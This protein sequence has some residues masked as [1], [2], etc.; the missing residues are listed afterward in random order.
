MRREPLNFEHP[1]P[2]LTLDE[3]YPAKWWEAGIF[4]L[5]EST[6]GPYMP[7]LGLIEVEE[8]LSAKLLEDGRCEFVFQLNQEVNDLFRVFFENHRRNLDV[9]FDGKLMTLRCNSEDLQE[10]YN[11][12]ETF[13]LPRARNEYATERRELV[14]Q[15]FEQMKKQE[16]CVETEAE[17]RSVW[18]DYRKKREERIRFAQENAWSVSF[19]VQ[20]FNQQYRE[21]VENKFVWWSKVLDDARIRKYKA[22]FELEFLPV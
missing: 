16:R 14:R 15:V 22:L 2:R 17:I 20:N 12:L 1:L 19:V 3:L 8:R 13:A 6:V 4:L 7:E 11:Y 10:N 5:E 21:I 9:T 18:S